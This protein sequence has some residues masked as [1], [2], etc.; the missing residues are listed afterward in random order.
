MFFIKPGVDD[1]DII[2]IRPYDINPWDNCRTV[3]YKTAIAQAEL[4]A[5]YL[6]LLRSGHCPAIPQRGEAFFY[7]KR[8]PDDGR[9]DWKADADSICRLIRA[10]TW[11]Y[12]GAF[13][14]LKGQRV[15]IWEGQPFSRDFFQ[16]AP[17]GRVC[18]VADNGTGEFAVRCGDGSV[19]VTKC[20]GPPN[21]VVGEQL[22]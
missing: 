16:D 14:E 19:L 12:P 4:L 2:A 7:P 15:M 13:S 3:Y 22:L 1:G 6:P 18:F 17:P 21:L 5:R 20:D 10:V 8:Q 11:P 9:I